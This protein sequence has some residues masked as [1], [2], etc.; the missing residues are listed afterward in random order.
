M[1]EWGREFANK[2]LTQK[3]EKEEWLQIR[4]YCGR[5]KSHATDALRKKMSVLPVDCATAI[6]PDHMPAL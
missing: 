6:V 1:D 5:R 4:K 2:W 3:F